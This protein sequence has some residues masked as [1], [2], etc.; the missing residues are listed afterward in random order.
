MGGYRLCRIKAA[1]HPYFIEAISTN[2][3]TIEELCYYMFHNT[4]LID[5][6]FV[7]TQLTRWVA[8]ELGLA[9]T[10]TAMERAFL[11]N[12]NLADFL[13]PVFEETGYLTAQ[14]IRQ[15]RADLEK[16]LRDPSYV[17]M[18]RKGDA[19]ARYGKFAAA[20]R[21]WRQALDLAEN[22]ENEEEL[23][24][25]QFRQRKKDFMASVWHNI[26]VTGMKM[27][28]YEERPGG[29]SDGVRA[30]EAAGE[31]RGARG[32]AGGLP[33]GC[34]ADPQPD[35]YGPGGTARA[36]AGAAGGI[37]AEAHGPVSQRR[38]RVRRKCI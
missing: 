21:T 1:E 4:A 24:E 35:R 19:L 11:E 22:L 3:Y 12:K 23:P 10:A 8:Q 5:A 38:R 31:V 27:L 16:Q 32:G 15:Y 28:D 7:G 2:V 17:R 33:G 36:D 30:R 13:V 18:K 6:T 14:E 29:L 26:G 25:E 9:K 20:G 34:R 37:P